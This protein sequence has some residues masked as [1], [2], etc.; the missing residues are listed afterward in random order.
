M[1][2]TTKGDKGRTMYT[3]TRVTQTDPLDQ[4]ADWGQEWNKKRKWQGASFDQN[5]D[6]FSV[7]LMSDEQAG[8]RYYPLDQPAFVAPKPRKPKKSDSDSDIESVHSEGGDKP[9]L[10]GRG[11]G[12][13]RGS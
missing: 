5:P 9:I 6:I 12:R 1:S 4:D 3:R 10:G 2:G 8:P 11:R 7:Y 13:E